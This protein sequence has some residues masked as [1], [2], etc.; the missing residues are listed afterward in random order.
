M[1]AATSSSAKAEAAG[2]VSLALT[3]HRAPASYVD[4]LHGIAP[5]PE[6]MG[7]LL[8]LA[9]GTSPADV[10][11]AIVPLASPNDLRI[12]ALFFIEQVLFRHDANYFRMLGLN[13]GANLEQIKEHHRLLMRL[14]HP[15]RENQPGDAGS[16][17]KES[18]ATRVNLAYNTLRDAGSRSRY[19]AGL[20]SQSVRSAVNAATVNGVS[21]NTM[22]AQRV[23]AR[24]LA[25]NPD[26]FWTIHLEPLFKRY[27]PQWVL[28]GTALLA[29]VLT[30]T[31]YLANPPVEVADNIGV[32]GE[33]L[34]GLPAKPVAPVT[35]L[36]LPLPVIEEAKDQAL[37]LDE[38]IARFENRNMQVVVTE[39]IATPS[40]VPK[41]RQA[42]VQAPQSPAKPTVWVPASAPKRLSDPVVT[43]SLALRQS[44]LPAI[45]EARPLQTQPTVVQATAQSP[46][47]LVQPPPQPVAEP[48]PWNPSILLD[49]LTEAYERGDAQDLMGLFDDAVRTNAGGRAETQRDYE[50][51]F[52]ATDLRDLRLDKITW[53]DDGDVLRGQGK[54]RL[55]QMRR[56]ESVLKIQSG[57]MRIELVRRGR[58]ILVSALYL[59]F[60]Q[61]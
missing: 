45:A 43:V 20:K 15:D 28:G 58:S 3:F 26:S 59:T 29:L 60:G 4:L 16:E 5:L 8:R 2:I 42:L 33:V 55:T 53:S 32:E 24:R 6:S 23:A 7:V 19:L 48:V 9:A 57:A 14:F 40:P 22:V 11:P 50:A 52:R 10:S 47:Q 37:N 1:S 12:A 35:T 17:W 54:F 56:G 25:A 51:L 30:G 31:V 49:Q 61:P 39:S 21:M 34:S 13:P 36:P 44:G 41:I 27:L 38:T 18:H 46:V